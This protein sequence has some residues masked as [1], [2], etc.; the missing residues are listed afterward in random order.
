MGRRLPTR[1]SRGAHHNTW[2][3][4]HQALV[5]RHLEPTSSWAARDLQ[6]AKV[7]QVPMTS[8]IAGWWPKVGEEFPQF[9]R[10]TARASAE[11]RDSAGVPSWGHAVAATWWRWAGHLARPINRDR[12]L[13]GGGMHGRRS[14][15]RGV[16]RGTPATQ[17]SARD[18]RTMST[19]RR[20]AATVGSRARSRGERHA[21][22]RC[23]GASRTR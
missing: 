1:A 21:T 2:R 17:Q 8:E 18:A 10:R 22:E 4:P 12:S 23:G 5:S 19:G 20:P 15:V 7:A 3:R 14:S 11:V 6:A 13:P 9:A 16:R